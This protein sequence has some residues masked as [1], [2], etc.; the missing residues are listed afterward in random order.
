[1]ERRIGVHAVGLWSVVVLLACALCAV[2]VA[3]EDTPLAELLHVFGCRESTIPLRETRGCFAERNATTPESLSIRGKNFPNGKGVRYRIQL[4]ESTAA[5]LFPDEHNSPELIEI[6]C[7]DVKTSMMFPTQLLTCQLLHPNVSLLENGKK[8][9][10]GAAWQRL[11]QAPMW[12]DVLVYTTPSEKAEPQLLGRLRRAVQIDI[13]SESNATKQSAQVD[14]SSHPLERLYTQKEGVEDPSTEDQWMEL[15]IGGLRKEL[16]TLFRRVFLSRL[17]SLA[18]I[19]ESLELQ[20]VRGVLLHGPPGNGKTLIARSLAKLLGPGAHLT[21]INAAEVLSKYVGESEKNLRDLFE[22]Y[23][24]G[25]STQ[26]EE[27]K[28]H[29][30]SPTPRKAP[31]TSDLHVLVIDEFE[32]LFRRRGSSSDESSAKAVYDG[33]TNTLLSLMDGLS[34]RNDLLVVG[35]TNRLHSID[36]ALLRPGRFEVLIEVPSPDT[37]SREEIFFIHTSPARD[38][39]YLAA[40]VNLEQLAMRTGGFAGAEV[41]GTVRS[42]LSYALLRFREGSVPDVTADPGVCADPAATAA[43]GCSSRLQST[44]FEVT[45]A[46][47][48]R[49]IED[50][51]S[52]K[53]E[54]SSLTYLSTGPHDIVE[55]VDHGHLAEQISRARQHADRIL[56]SR[57]IFS[58]VIAVSGIAGSGKTTVAQKMALSFPFTTVRFLSGRRLVEIEDHQ[59]QLAEIRDALSESSLAESGLVVLD[60]VDILQES[61]SG[62]PLLL[63]SFKNLLYEYTT[64]WQGVRRSLY[65]GSTGDSG[66]GTSFHARGGLHD[67]GNRRILVVTATHSEAFRE[68]PYD[69]LLRS[70]TLQQSEMAELLS[71]YC[72]ANKTEAA[73]LTSFYPSMSF[74]TFL[75]ITELALQRLGEGHADDP[76]V[77]P[78]FFAFQ[79]ANRDDPS[80]SPNDLHTLQQSSGYFAVRTEREVSLFRDAVQQLVLSMHLND[81][82]LDMAEERSTDFGAELLW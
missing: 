46:D 13:S 49:A 1:M 59:K 8:S 2:A 71:F 6:P 17:P 35:L 79:G 45:A 21:V 12:F 77:M 65:G 7:I 40:D 50:I 36:A 11:R 27:D 58:G 78:W 34:S 62:Y 37:A 26:E 31:I 44:Q 18:N 60:D 75:R 61:F 3:T 16:R 32:A 81:P 15:G 66:R 67:Q 72:V 55:F 10:Q 33:V 4:R 76:F 39:G 73:K 57:R 68:I 20:H 80:T 54:L 9:L 82:F 14:V 23:T 29:G 51:R 43:L 28:S 22:G 38:S 56:T 19:T 53:D 52:A 25:V 5:S 48:E 42:A 24:T 69:V 64:R 47:F 41:A 30:A 70:H 63:A 74:R